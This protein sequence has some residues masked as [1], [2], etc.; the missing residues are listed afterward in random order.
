M[1]IKEKNDSQSIKPNKSGKRSATRG[2]YNLAAG[3]SQIRLRVSQQPAEKRNPAG[4]SSE[5]AIIGNYFLGIA[6]KRILC[7]PGQD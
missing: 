5:V 4:E 3:E 1:Q 7:F 2:I 6:V